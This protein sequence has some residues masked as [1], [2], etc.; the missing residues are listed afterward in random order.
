MSNTNLQIR[1]ADDLRKYFANADP[2]DVAALWEVIRA[3]PAMPPG[4]KKAI[5]SIT[6]I[7]WEAARKLAAKK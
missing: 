4:V 7:D 3:W 6:L 2:K 1:N 5:L